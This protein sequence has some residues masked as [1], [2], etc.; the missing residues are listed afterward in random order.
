MKKFMKALAVVFCA[1]ILVA[2]SVAATFAYLT[3]KTETIANTFTAGNISITLKETTGEQ[4]KMVPGTFI[5]KNPTVTVDAASES[6]WLFVKIE[7]SDNFDTYM[8]YTVADVWKIVPGETNVYYCLVDTSETDP[9]LVFPVLQDNS[10]FAKEDCTKAQYNSLN[11]ANWPSLSVT[12]YAIQYAGF[13]AEANIAD[14]WGEV[15]S[16]ESSNP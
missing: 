13:T 4:Y 14:T 11:A 5:D 8:T 10:V 15:L 9:Q 2:G 1:A 12:A 6:C 16:A 3:T 7:K